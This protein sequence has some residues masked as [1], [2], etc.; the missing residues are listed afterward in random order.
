MVLAKSEDIS[1][2]LINNLTGKVDYLY[3]EIPVTVP[4][5]NSPFAVCSVDTAIVDMNAYSYTT[6]SIYV[7]VQNSSNGAHNR[8]KINKMID[9]IASIFPIHSD[10]Y[11]F[12]M[13]PQ[14]IPMGNDSKGYNVTKIQIKTYVYKK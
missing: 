7:F 10:N 11:Y 14:I 13:M 6:S 4:T 12:D 5:N 2:E 8:I 9:A 3:N 1:Q